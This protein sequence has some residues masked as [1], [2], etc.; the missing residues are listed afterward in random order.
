MY[1]S[2]FPCLLRA[3]ISKS[4]YKND[5]M[6]TVHH[7][8]TQLRWRLVASNCD[9]CFPFL[10]LVVLVLCVCLDRRMCL[11]CSCHSTVSIWHTLNNPLRPQECCCHRVRYLYGCGFVCG[12]FSVGRFYSSVR[13]RGKHVNSFDKAASSA[14]RCGV[15]LYGSGS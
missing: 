11:L 5:R 10:I 14:H 6:L 15:L 9:G 1:C 2:F 3:L 13:V 4:S 8:V 12:E 7:G